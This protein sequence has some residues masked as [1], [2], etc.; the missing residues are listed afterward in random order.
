[1][2]VQITSEYQ[3]FGSKWDKCV[4][5]GR[6]KERDFTVLF[7]EVLSTDTWHFW[8]RDS[9]MLYNQHNNNGMVQ[10]LNTLAWSIWCADNPLSSK[11]LINMN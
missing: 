2:G 8:Y 11:A 7:K 4:K 3:T 6:V 9:D 5:K 1:M 10:D